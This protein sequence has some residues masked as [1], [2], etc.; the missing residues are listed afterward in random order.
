MFLYFKMVEANGF[1]IELKWRWLIMLH[2]IYTFKIFLCWM[3][4]NF[5]ICRK[6]SVL[7]VYHIGS[8]LGKVWRSSSCCRALQPI[9]ICVFQN[10]AFGQT[11]YFFDVPGFELRSRSEISENNHSLAIFEMQ[12]IHI[13]IMLLESTSVELDPSK[14]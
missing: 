9:T 12:S 8:I 7:Y 10:T 6:I 2:T 3:V 13:S 4:I 5:W 14:P 11:F 1:K